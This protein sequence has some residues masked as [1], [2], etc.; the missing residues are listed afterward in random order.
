MSEKS[1]RAFAKE[2][3]VSKTT[4]SDAMKRLLINGNSQG[5]G[6]PTYLTESEQIRLA[7]EIKGQKTFQPPV[8][9]AEAEYVDC[10]IYTPKPIEL[11]VANS[12]LSRAV[13]RI[14]GITSIHQ[15]LANRETLASALIK[16]AAEQG[17]RA[18]HEMFAAYT[19]SMLQTFEE[20][21][22]QAARAFGVVAKPKEE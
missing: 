19:G 21:Q 16:R 15:F 10:E 18:G 6:K 12:Q 11:E 9:E 2:L 20:S 5:P 14:Q 1:I 4:V 8:L 22:E 3:K 17:A 7:Q 13:Q